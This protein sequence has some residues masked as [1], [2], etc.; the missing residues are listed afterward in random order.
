MAAILLYR[1]SPSVWPLIP[2]FSPFGRLARLAPQR[3][4]YGL[5]SE[6]FLPHRGMQI[7]IGYLHDHTL[8][9]K[10]FSS[11]PM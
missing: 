4:L 11:R 10:T 2:R 1:R 7:Q 3:P 8:V 9:T 5:L 6:R